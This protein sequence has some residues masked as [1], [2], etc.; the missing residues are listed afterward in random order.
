MPRTI[1][2]ML[3]RQLP[4]LSSSLPAPLLRPAPRITSTATVRPIA[5]SPILSRLAPSLLSGAFRRPTLPAAYVPGSV[6]GALA[7]A[8]HSHGDEYQPS[9]RVRK[10]R[11]GFLARLRS[12]SGRKVLARRRFKGRRSL[13]H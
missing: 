13:T 7:Q 9:Q 11:H 1:P 8:R 6:L 2:R 12:R 5:F 4:K 10:R 3:L